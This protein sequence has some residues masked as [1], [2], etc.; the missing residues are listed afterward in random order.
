MHCGVEPEPKRTLVP[1]APPDSDVN[2]PVVGSMKNALTELAGLVGVKFG[3]WL[4]RYRN[5]P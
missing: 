1:L 5:L 4:A 2:L 3:P